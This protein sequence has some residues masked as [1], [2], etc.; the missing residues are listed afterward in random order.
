MAVLHSVLAIYGALDQVATQTTDPQMR[1]AVEKMLP[2]TTAPGQRGWFAQIQDFVT[3]R[4]R[5]QAAENGT[6]VAAAEEAAKVPT[7][8]QAMQEVMSARE[9]PDAMSHRIRQR[10]A[11]AGM[12]VRALA[13]MKEDLSISVPVLESLD[14][15]PFNTAFA[16]AT[17]QVPMSGPA[18][19]G[20][21]SADDSGGG[22]PP[23]SS[24]DVLIEGGADGWNEY[25]GDLAKTRE[26]GMA[27][28]VMAI[29]PMKALG[30]S[31]S[32]PVEHV[33]AADGTV[34]DQ[35]KV[36][37]E[38][39]EIDGELCSLLTTEFSRTPYDIK[40]VLAVVEP[41]NWDNANKF[42]AE[43]KPEGLAPDGR[44]SQILEEVSTHPDIYRIKTNLKYVNED[45]PDGTYVINYDFADERGSDDSQ[46]VKVDSGYIRVGASTDGKGVSV[47]TS[48]MVRIDGLSPTAV[49]VFAHAMGWL[50][51]GEMMMFGE[52]TDGPP[53]PLVG[54][55]ESPDRDVLVTPPA[56]KKAQA[57]KPGQEQIQPV[58][59]LFVKEATNAMADYFEIATSETAV[60]ADK[61]LKGELSV[62]DMVE[63]TTKL[64]GRLASEPFRLLE[65]MMK[66]AVGPASS[67]SSTDQAKGDGSQ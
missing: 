46:Q 2:G 52:P 42:F 50:S 59:R 14:L 61:W 18:D 4:A 23:T 51:I 22:S 43:M 44:S 35:G 48:K 57:T 1:A 32:P 33:T 60:V 36:T 47:L 9:A 54:W 56:N 6:D 45:R 53:D 12:G 16:L 62:G 20:S 29:P 40:K 25:M 39:I 38:V 21:D 30:E 10:A 19:S 58:S 7:A 66:N 8:D 31:I 49:A 17:P 27:P 13:K 67:K 3:A 15:T 28:E 65:K 63:H 41:E 26:T 64:G 37:S 34:T 5:E 24:L 55:K 11:Y